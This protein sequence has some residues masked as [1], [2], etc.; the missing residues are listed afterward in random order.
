MR[1]LILFLAC[2]LALVH[3]TAILSQV[4][5]GAPAAQK[6]VNHGGKIESKYDG[7]NHETVVRLQKMKV[8]CD[9]IK[10][11]FV[12]DACVSIE[13]SLHC[14]GVQL[15]YVR[16]VTLQIVFENKD[17]V[18]SHPLDQR[19]LQV[20]ID[21]ETL[22]LGRMQLANTAVPGKWDTKLEVL[23]ATVPYAVFKKIAQSQAVEMQVGQSAFELRE[24]NRLALRDL[25]SR[26]VDTRAKN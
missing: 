16:N 12:K 8:T 19:E 6:P 22:R 5:S 25:D 11:K 13:I 23:E 7:F 1:K 24:K 2:A 4:Q 21:A 10:D 20:V 15:N 18:H 26:V 14:P 17:W 3:P 9:G